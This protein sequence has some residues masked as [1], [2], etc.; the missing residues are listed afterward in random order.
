MAASSSSSSSIISTKNQRHK[1]PK[2]KHKQQC[3]NNRND[4]NNNDYYYPD[5]LSLTTTTTTTTTAAAASLTY[6]FVVRSLRRRLWK[7]FC[8]DDCISALRAYQATLSD[9]RCWLEEEEELRRQHQREAVSSS[10]TT[11]DSNP[12]NNDHYMKKLKIR[13]GAFG[14]LMAFHHSQSLSLI[15]ISEP[16][17]PC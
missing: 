6:N 15:H 14:I 11:A 10:T 1:K 16:T 3:C 9:F 12:F 13:S 4:G 2:N 7:A 8:E 5:V 17:R